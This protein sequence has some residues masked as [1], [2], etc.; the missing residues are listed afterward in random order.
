MVLISK[1]VLYKGMN[2]MIFP[3]EIIKKYKLKIGIK[4]K[5]IPINSKSFKVEILN[6]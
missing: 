5:I 3:R 4:L 2:A 1:V 6:D